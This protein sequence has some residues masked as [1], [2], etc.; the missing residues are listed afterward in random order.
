[1]KGCGCEEGGSARTL[2]PG[3]P[4]R[5][6]LGSQGLHPVTLCPSMEASWAQIIIPGPGHC[7]E[8][9][10]SSGS[11]ALAGGLEQQSSVAGEG[12]ESKTPK[13][14][15]MRG[16]AGRRPRELTFSDLLCRVLPAHPKPT[17]EDHTHAC[18]QTHGHAHR[19]IQR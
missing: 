12:H 9:P 3:P 5:D 15:P 11:P 14:H 8:N 1:M 10:A 16:P 13:A 18:T 4:A 6:Q 17:Y 7:T 2:A 19:F